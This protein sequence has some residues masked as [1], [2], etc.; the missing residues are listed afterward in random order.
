MEEGMLVFYIDDSHVY[1]GR[2]TDVEREENRYTF[3]IDSYG[4]CE[5]PYR[6]ASGAVGKTVFFSEEDAQA[7]IDSESH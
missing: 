6:I 5:G 4:C 7:A 2:V 1:S 3:S